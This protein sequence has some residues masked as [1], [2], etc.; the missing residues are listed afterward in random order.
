MHAT[1]GDVSL[2]SVEEWH[3]HDLA[4]RMREADRFEVWAS[5]HA[6][7][8]EALLRAVSRSHEL[9]AVERQGRCV[10]LFGV[11]PT[12]LLMEKGSP[13]LLGSDELHAIR[14]PFLRHSR[15]LMNRLCE[16]YRVLTNWVHVDNHLSL[17]WLRWLQFEIGEAQPYGVE[18]LPFHPVTRKRGD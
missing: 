14:I 12:N 8:L 4:P 13:W 15:P 2:T 1:S 16:T 7:P 9:W 11:V 17:A 6:T 3:P 5:D 18:R 10:C